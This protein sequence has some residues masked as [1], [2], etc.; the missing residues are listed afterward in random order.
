MYKLTY[1]ELERVKKGIRKFNSN[2]VNLAADYSIAKQF[3]HILNGEIC[4]LPGA[5]VL[6][7]GFFQTGLRFQGYDSIHEIYDNLQ[8]QWVNVQAS[9]GNLQQ[10]PMAI[11][12]QDERIR[13]LGLIPEL[14]RGRRRVWPYSFATKFF[15][16][17]AREHFPIMD[18]K[19]RVAIHNFQ[20]TK[21]VR[22]RDLLINKGKPKGQGE[23]IE[24]Y[25]KW[26]NFYN[27]FFIDNAEDT[28]EQIEQCD[29][30]A[31]NGS[32]FHIQNT[33]LRVLDKYF[34]IKGSN[35]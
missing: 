11:Q 2:P 4:H 21:N 3:G 23:C 18:S 7:D 1:D 35:G 6:L 26:I 10:L 15:H 14:V 34:Y 27:R 8:Q 33:L 24:E 19:S 5:I 17:C 20:I 25:K 22:R 12:E 28:L 32:P 16:W 9:L 29:E 31:Q 30:E 13:L